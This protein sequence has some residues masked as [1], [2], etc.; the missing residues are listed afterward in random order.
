[1]PL[2]KG[3]KNLKEFGDNFVWGGDRL[4]SD[5]KFKASPDGKAKFILPDIKC[6][7]ISSNEF[8]LSTRRGRQFNSMILETK[9]PQTGGSDRHTLFINSHD[10]KTYGFQEGAKVTVISAFGKAECILKYADVA[11]STVQMFWPE[12]NVLIPTETDPISGEPD[13]NVCV[14]LI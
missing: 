12:C 7:E 2:Y 9:D 4:F 10:A 3:I 11:K 1:M 8:I 5:M 6:Y 14:K 13:Y